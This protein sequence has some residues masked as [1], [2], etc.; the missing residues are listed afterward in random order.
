MPSLKC[1]ALAEAQEALPLLQFM[2]ERQ[3]NLIGV[4]STGIDRVREWLFPSR[5]KTMKSKYF[6]RNLCF[7][8]L[9]VSLGLAVAGTTTIA[10]AQIPTPKT[11][12]IICPNGSRPVVDCSNP[13]SDVCGSSGSSSSGSGGNSSA[14]GRWL[15][16]KLHGIGCPDPADVA[17]ELNAKGNKAF[18]KGDY[19]AA[20]SF[21]ERALKKSP[22]DNV[23]KNNLARAREGFAKKQADK[24]RA[25]LVKKQAAERTSTQAHANDDT[26]KLSER[27]KNLDARIAETE[28]RTKQLGLAKS[29]Q[30]FAWYTGM[31][32][33]ARQRMVDGLVSRLRDYA[34]SKSESKMQDGFLTRIKKMKPKEINKLA[35][36]LQHLE[37]K[38]T[39]LKAQ[40][41]QKWLRSFSPKAPREVLIN[42]SKLAIDTVKYEQGL[43]KL[44]ED[45]ETGTVQSRQEAALGLISLVLDNPLVME[46]PAIKELKLVAGGAYD[47]LEAGF[48]IYVLDRDVESLIAATESQLSNQKKIARQ[49][50]SLY[51][52]RS[53]IKAKLAKLPH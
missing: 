24:Q 45:L 37:S 38:V 51:D 49:L 41:F 43:F 25:A 34:V 48:T 7:A 13:P 44:G 46:F 8:A 18:G 21:Y 39:L 22:N 36:T 10:I 30:T 17:V 29:G 28:R 4:R 42:G 11:C 32:E 16:C 33:I 5:R 50:K 35:D 23:I 19:A 12:T 26:A 47:V 20:A 27:L 53:V 14:A 3:L 2:L 9:V 52:E 15:G 1:S 40:R 6:G 31:S